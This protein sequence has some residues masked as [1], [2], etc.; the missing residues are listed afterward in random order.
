MF[1]IFAGFLQCLINMSSD[2]MKH[3]VINQDYLLLAKICIY[4][5][6]L[7]STLPYNT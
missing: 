7:E 3:H 1:G 5:T 6:I 2:S 4:S